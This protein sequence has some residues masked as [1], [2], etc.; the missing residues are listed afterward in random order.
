LVFDNYTEAVGP[1]DTSAAAS[2]SRR[3][4]AVVFLDDSSC[5]DSL[6]ELAELR[7]ELHA[8]KI[9]AVIVMDQSRKSSDREQAALQQAQEALKLKESATVEVLRATKREDYMLSLITDASQDMAGMLHLFSILSLDI[10]HTSSSHLVVFFTVYRFFSGH[11]CR[12]TAR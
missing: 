2:H 4:L 10:L 1:S 5:A 11:Y 3:T 6:Q 8:M 7:Q 9:Q 12:R